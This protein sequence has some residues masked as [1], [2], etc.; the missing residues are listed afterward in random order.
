[1]YDYN[2][3]EQDYTFPHLKLARAYVPL[4]K[5]VSLYPPEEAIKKGTIFPELDM[6]YA[7]EKM[8]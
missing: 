8:R 7:G 5:Y 4:Q 6:P 2:P 1:M 3:Y